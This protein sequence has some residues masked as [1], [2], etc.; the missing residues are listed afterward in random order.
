MKPQ[1]N[2]DHYNGSY[3]DSKERFVSYWHQLNIIA[4][5][6]TRILLDIGI[7][8]NFVSRYLRQHK[9]QVDVT[10]MDID[11][12]L[13]PDVVGTVLAI[14]FADN[15]FDCISCCEVLEHLQYSEFTK[16]LKEIKRISKK[17]LIL[18]LPDVTTAYHIYI[19]LPRIKPIKKL[20]NHPFHRPVEHVFD[21]EHY[22]EIGRKGYALKRI[23]SDIINSGFYILNTYRIYEFSY[24]RFFILKRG[25]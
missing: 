5:L 1:V 12:A 14:P 3:Y 6:N 4:S 11:H 25:M 19:E 23:E 7:G 9:L 8:N 2:Q 15:S 20:I 18:S 24:H 13:C 16:A 22:W 10:T 17:Y 21:G